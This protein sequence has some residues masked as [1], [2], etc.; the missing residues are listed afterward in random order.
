[1][2]VDVG[3]NVGFF[4]LLAATNHVPVVAIEPGA[5]NVEI[6]L[7]NLRRAW[8]SLDVPVEVYPVA[9][10]S[11]PG[12]QTIHG[13][14]QGAS[15][16]QGW[17]GVRSTHRRRVPVTT[18]DRLLGDRL[19]LLGQAA[20]IKLDVEG[21]EF[22][23]LKGSKRTLMLDPSP[24]WI[25]EHSLT[26]NFPMGNNPRF[27]ALF[28]VFWGAGYIARTVMGDLVTESDVDGWIRRGSIDSAD[29]N[30]VFLR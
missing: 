27:R 20:V 16:L 13:T 21:Y 14:G 10:G 2:V 30:F 9:L 11:Q 28:D 22:E 12:V 17:G 23:V 18:V 29:I 26:Q 5:A 19:A 7:Q 15:L 8:P 24:T 1:M 6:L 25:V 4:T 3:A